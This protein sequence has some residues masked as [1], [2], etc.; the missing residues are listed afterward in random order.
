VCKKIPTSAKKYYNRDN[1]FYLAYA[2]FGRCFKNGLGLMSVE[3]EVDIDN[4]T[5]YQKPIK[6]QY[7]KWARLSSGIF[8]M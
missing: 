5:L 4:N 8:V 6:F 1:S 3:I 7:P 2:V